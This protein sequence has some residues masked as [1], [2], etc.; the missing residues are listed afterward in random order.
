MRVP[1]LVG[2]QQ[3]AIAD[4]RPAP[5]ARVHDRSGQRAPGQLRQ[6]RTRRYCPAGFVDG[7]RFTG[8]H[9]FVALQSADLQQPDVGGD[10]VAQAQLDDVAGHPRGDLD[11]GLPPVA[12]DRCVVADARVQ[13]LGGLLI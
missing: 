8:Q 3:V 11:C 5:A 13:R 9:R 1:V 4:H 12:Q 10:D 7:Q 2:E 6:R